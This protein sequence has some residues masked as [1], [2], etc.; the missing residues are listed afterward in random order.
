MAMRWCLFLVLLLAAC[1][2]EEETPQ[3]ELLIVSPHGSAIKMEFANAFSSWHRQKYGTEV[4]VQWPLI[5]SGGTNDIRRN[6]E[7]QYVTNKRGTCDY[8]LMFGGGSAV[9][10]GL[11][12]LGVLEPPA[13]TL[14]LAAALARAPE[15]IHG[16]PLRGTGNLWFGATMSNFGVVVNKQR[17]AELHLEPPR[18]WLDLTG[19][20][21]FGELSLADPSKGGSIRTCFE[22]VLQQYGWKEGWPVLVRMFANSDAVQQTGSNPGEEA[23]TGNVAA[24]VVIDFFGRTAIIKS[25]SGIMQ[26][27]VP[28]GGSSLDPD[29]LAVLKGAPHAELASHFVEFVLSPEGQRLWVQRVG[30][31]GGPARRALGRMSI[32]PEIYE[33]DGAWLTDPTNPFTAKNVLKV[34]GKASAQR[35]SFLGELMRAALIDNHDALRAARA[36]VRRAGD[37][38]EL[39]AMF[40]AL[41]FA[42]EETAAIAKQWTGDPATQLRLRESWRQRYRALFEEI[43]RKARGAGRSGGAW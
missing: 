9:F 20:G 18:T 43:E 42:E 35:A 34:D 33:R 11:V 23:A 6:L 3:A 19:P 25:G 40:D 36:A 7:I 38:P 30:T 13:M 16:I 17:L 31:P 41:P 5:G 39:M 1:G 37:P 22:M 12:K 28:E 8:D 21:Y 4:K 10:D 26:F 2:R 24:G 14:G 27:I 15:G 32:L 29:P